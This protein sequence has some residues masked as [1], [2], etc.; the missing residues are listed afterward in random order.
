MI[1]LNDK[2]IQE[3]FDGTQSSNG[4][5]I[6]VLRLPINFSYNQKIRLAQIWIDDFNP[7]WLSLQFVPFS[8][9]PK[10]LAFNLGNRLI[11]LNNKRSW[12]VMVHELWLG[13]DKETSF[14]FACWGWL[15]KQLI[16]SLFR[17]LNPS[18][19]NTH[20][21]LYIKMLK[22]INVKAQYLPLFGNIPIIPGNLKSGD[23][24]AAKRNVREVSFVL[25]GGIHTGVE[26]G[27]LLRELKFFSEESRLPVTLKLVG[28]NGGEQ[29]RWKKEWETAG[30]KVEVLGEK[31]EA[32]VSE[33]L[34]SSSFGI[35]TTPAALIEK[36]GSVAAMREHG[37]KVLCISRPWHPTGYTQTNFPDEITVY[38]KG[39]ISDFIN[40]RNNL[41]SMN[42]ISDVANKFVK[43]LANS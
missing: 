8:F 23:D 39:I 36:S 28:R 9:H 18:C 22:T 15:Q 35:S 38:S 17:K 6:P 27:D 25:F 42:S 7:Q 1:S 12:H 29:S 20:T 40:N 41:N 24:V 16:K 4:L 21:D 10:G 32:V 13:M 34:S 2:F 11:Q 5:Q 14:K 26:L 33:I 19:I 3:S 31:P 30:L 43:H 37:L